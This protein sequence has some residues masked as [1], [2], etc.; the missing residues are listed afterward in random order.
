MVV[1]RCV[2][3]LPVSACYKR[4]TLDT[5]PRIYQTLVTCLGLML[6]ETAAWNLL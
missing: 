6:S 5:K 2:R 4:L 3:N 1:Y